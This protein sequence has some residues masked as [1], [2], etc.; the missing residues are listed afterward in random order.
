[1]S[2]FVQRTLLRGDA[3]RRAMSEALLAEKLLLT[4][5]GRNT[6]ERNET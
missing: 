2:I 3:H 4:P 6:R 1:M 5:A